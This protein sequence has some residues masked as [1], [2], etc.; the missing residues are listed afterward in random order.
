MNQSTL[1]DETAILFTPLKRRKPEDTD[2]EI[3]A[4]LGARLILS[5]VKSLSMVFLGWTLWFF[6]VFQLSNVWN[7]MI[8]LTVYYKCDWMKQYR[9]RAWS[10]PWHTSA[11]HWWASRAVVY[12]SVFFFP[13]L[14]FGVVCT[15]VFFSDLV[16]MTFSLRWVPQYHY[17]F[18]FYCPRCSLA[19]GTCLPVQSL[20]LQ[21]LQ[22]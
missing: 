22:R 9:W 16:L 3:W 21:C 2:V 15:F 11:M 8:I 10:S 20:L 13:P 14:R 12:I 7:E 18:L 5:L 19:S 1:C 17:V 4:G 6:L